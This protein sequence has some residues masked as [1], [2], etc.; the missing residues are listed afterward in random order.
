[1]HNQPLELFWLDL[2]LMENI[3]QSTMLVTSNKNDKLKKYPKTYMQ[4]A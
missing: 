3:V 1:M 2:L 4:L